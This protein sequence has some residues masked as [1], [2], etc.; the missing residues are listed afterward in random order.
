M[1]HTPFY[2]ALLSAFSL[3]AAPLCFDLGSAD[4]PVR[5]NFTS[6][7]AK[8]PMWS[9]A[10]LFTANNKIERKSGINLNS[11]RAVPP[12]YYNELTCDHIG[13]KGGATLTFSV[14]DGQ[15]K[16]WIL[17]GRAGGNAA[18][19]W[20]IKVHAGPKTAAMTYAGGA[21][22]HALMGG[23]L[24]QRAREG[25]LLAR[26]QHAVAAARGRGHHH[27]GGV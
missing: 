14:P 8:S 2:L 25:K 21:E 12:I 9:G 3:G 20:D 1:T 22:I 18:Q 19:V 7:D 26:K 6:L 4:S 16:V 27:H 23:P 24:P 10:K 15:Y 11:G 5:K 17:T 13:S